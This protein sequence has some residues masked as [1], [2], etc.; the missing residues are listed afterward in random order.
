MRV[1]GEA[2]EPP[3]KSVNT[4]LALLVE[5]YLQRLVELPC[6]APLAEDCI[7]ATLDAVADELR[8]ALEA[9]QQGG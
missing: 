2:H 5:R 1:P 3:A 8:H 4:T 7:H 9:H 6:G